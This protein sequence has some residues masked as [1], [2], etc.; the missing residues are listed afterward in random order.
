MLLKEKTQSS[1]GYNPDY[2]SFSSHKKVKIQCD[3]CKVEFDKTYGHYVKT[4]SS[5]IKK[6]CCKKC[7]VLKTH[8]VI[9][10]NGT[11]S[12]INEKRAATN[13]KKFGCVAPANN[14][15]IQQKIQ[16]DNLEKYGVA[17]HVQ[18]E[19]VKEK[20]KATNL[21]RY[22]VDNV[23]KSSEVQNKIKKKVWEKYGCFSPAQIHMPID[24]IMKLTD[25]NWLIDQHITQKKCL[26]K[27][28]SDLGLSATSSTIA[29]YC[30]R[31]GIE[32]QKYIVSEPEKEIC[33][34]LDEL[35]IEYLPSNREVIKP[36]ELDIYIPSS[37]LAIEYCGLYWHSDVYLDKKYHSDK[38]KACTEKGIRLI[39]IFEDEWLKK[40][41]IV[42]SRIQHILQ[43]SSNK[44]QA[45]KCEIV[46]D[47]NFK[48][49][50]N[51]H[52]IQGSNGY[53]VGYGLTYNGILV[54]V[55]TF[56]PPRFNNNYEWELIRFASNGSI[57]GAASRLFAAFVRDHDPKSV[58]SYCD[59][60]WGTG[61]VYE[62]IGFKQERM[63]SPGYHY[64]KDQ[65]RFNRLKFKK[66]RLIEMGFDPTKSESQITEE[67]GLCKIYDCGHKVFVYTP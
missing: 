16:T 27:I 40:P 44:I 58:I 55:M 60:R 10:L 32:I 35:G 18:R 45:R 5:V 26:T 8:E 38:L 28:A 6:D 1:F 36:K 67:I 9:K 64:T 21:S 7:K 34:F 19:E 49:F 31:H 39:T 53:S 3:Y 59:L 2:L 46:K 57:T 37:N 22:G 33:K 23:F 25:K 41:E 30:R 51:K 63:L 13:L 43:K 14:K 61:E 17:H 12:Q 56:A 24:A 66:S 42:K 52:H 29:G 4:L 54:S 50:L 62:K 47:G 20:S 48:E 11:Q 65:K 15:D